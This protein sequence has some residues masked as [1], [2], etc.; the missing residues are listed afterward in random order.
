MTKLSGL[1]QPLRRAAQAFFRDD[2]ALK[3]DEAG[4]RLTLEDRSAAPA[5]RLPSA[6]ELAAERQRRELKVMLVQLA[7]TLDEMPETR[8]TLRHLVFVEHAL[9]KKGLRAL[10]KVP[11]EVLIRALEQFEGLVTNWSADGLANLRSK[12]AVTVI[13]R[14]TQPA[15]T[16]P[17][18]LDS[19]FDPE[20]VEAVLDPPRVAAARAIEAARHAAFEDSTLERLALEF[21][22]ARPA[23][24]KVADRAESQG[25]PAS[26]SAQVRAPGVGTT[27][28]GPAHL[29]ARTLD[30]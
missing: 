1:L 20:R 18:G 29:Q 15:T 16:E 13:E 19:M 10:K 22:V 5:Q 28:L 9:H 23:A 12:M 7:D 30:A 8:E 25:E 21:G 6:T 4:L 3:R 11:L 26:P 2:V 17:D 24:G 14:E 27:P